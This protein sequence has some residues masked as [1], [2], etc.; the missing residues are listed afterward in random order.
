MMGQAAM[1]DML[2][3][4]IANSVNSDANNVDFILQLKHV[5]LIM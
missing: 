2:K 5:I 4:A 3:Y 1:P